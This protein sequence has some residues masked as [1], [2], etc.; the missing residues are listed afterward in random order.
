MVG[1]IV[2]VRPSAHVDTPCTVHLVDEGDKARLGLPTQDGSDLSGTTLA[3]QF[4]GD[5]PAVE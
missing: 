2:H 3:A 5:S 1:C 4:S